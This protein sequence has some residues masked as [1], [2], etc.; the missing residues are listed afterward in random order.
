MQPASPW[1]SS[2]ASCACPSCT[3]MVSA[4]ASVASRVPAPACLRCPARPT[5]PALS[6]APELLPGHPDDAGLP[7]TPLL[8]DLLAL[9]LSSYHLCKFL[10]WP[11]PRLLP[12]GKCSCF[13]NQQ[14]ESRSPSIWPELPGVSTPTPP[15]PG[16]LKEVAQSDK[17]VGPQNQ[18]GPGL[19][20]EP[21]ALCLAE[22]S[23][24]P[25]KGKAGWQQLRVSSHPWCSC[26][27][28]PG[29]FRNHY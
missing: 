12:R 20:R 3:S 23:T 28:S 17:Y 21:R 27:Q 8:P 13:K 19:V 6:R 4:Q 22:D 29:S 11:L 7:T 26:L 18:P 25:Q 9:C 5:D 1:L 24:Q 10:S 16:S 14:R 15:A 2:P